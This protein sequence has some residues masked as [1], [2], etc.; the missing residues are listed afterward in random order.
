[1]FLDG[2]GIHYSIQGGWLW[3]LWGRDCIVVHL[4]NGVLRIGT[5]DADNLS[6]FLRKRIEP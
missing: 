1:M 6:V 3:N 2:W 4:K 5:D